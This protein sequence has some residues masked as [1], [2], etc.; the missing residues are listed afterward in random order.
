MPFFEVLLVREV[1]QYARVTV[2]AKNGREAEEKALVA[3]TAAE[4]WSGENES[5]R[6]VPGETRRE[7]E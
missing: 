1:T 4:D 5:R 7:D 2:E 3:K 6:I